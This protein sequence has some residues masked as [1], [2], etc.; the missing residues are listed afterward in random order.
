M[1]EPAIA[2]PIATTCV[3]CSKPR[4]T[5]ISQRCVRTDRRAA[6]RPVRLDGD[7][8]LVCISDQV[9]KTKDMSRDREW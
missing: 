8:I 1:T 9:D 3:N 4:T 7:C 5:S 2:I 6:G